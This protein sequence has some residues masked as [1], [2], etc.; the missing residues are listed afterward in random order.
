MNC[1]TTNQMVTG[2]PKEVIEGFVLKWEEDSTS[3]YSSLSHRAPRGIVSRVVP[4][5]GAEIVSHYCPLSLETPRGL[6]RGVYRSGGRDRFYHSPLSP[7]TR[8][9][10]VRGGGG[11]T[12]VGSRGHF[13][14]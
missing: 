6:V 14:L 7:E 3:Q 11:Y 5:W 9:G 8:M 13:Q 4:K 10:L 2:C 12:E 1:M